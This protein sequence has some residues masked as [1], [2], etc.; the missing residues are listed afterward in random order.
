MQMLEKAYALYLRKSDFLGLET[1]TERAAL[2]GKALATLGYNAHDI[3][4]TGFALGAR[5]IPSCTFGGVCTC[6]SAWVVV[7]WFEWTPP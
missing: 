2:A 6:S 3:S 4:G 5:S 1:A 7:I